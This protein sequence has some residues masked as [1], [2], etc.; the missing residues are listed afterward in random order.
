MPAAVMEPKGTDAPIGTERESRKVKAGKWRR[1]RGALGLRGRL[2][3]RMCAIRSNRAKESPAPPF[4]SYIDLI[5]PQ[6]Y[7][8]TLTGDRKRR[9]FVRKQ[10][11]EVLDKVTQIGHMTGGGVSGL[12]PAGRYTEGDFLIAFRGVFFVAPPAMKK[13]PRTPF[14]EGSRGVFSFS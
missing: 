8:A 3:P 11:L 6:H 10:I 7:A 1:P 5:L 2:H 4:F 12:H 13:A 14:K 9:I